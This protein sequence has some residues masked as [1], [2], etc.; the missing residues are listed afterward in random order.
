MTTN[1]AS[2]E[3]QTDPPA[4][5]KMMAAQRRALAENLAA[6]MQVAGQP[7]RDGQPGKFSQSELSTAT[8]I[9]RST[10]SRIV[11]ENAGKPPNPDL[12]T[13]CRL[14]E[15]L[16]IPVFFLLMRAPDWA[17]LAEAAIYYSDVM[18]DE[19]LREA[20]ISKTQRAKVLSGVEL[21]ERLGLYRSEENVI[22]PSDRHDEIQADIALRNE[23]TRRAII[24][25]TAVSQLSSRE[26]H[27]VSLTTIGAIFGA[28]QL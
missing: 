17:K 22:A 1:D 7:G 26:K 13:L 20:I 21:A 11:T 9:A 8:G 4:L 19:D 15:A 18:D 5:D 2:P 28:S 27:R 12:E 14:A 10:L 6:A 23:R 25:A 3:E 16:N 24:S